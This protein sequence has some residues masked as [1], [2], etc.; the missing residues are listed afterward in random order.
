MD[1][2]S[3]AG[4]RDVAMTEEAKQPLFQLDREYAQ[5]MIAHAEEEAPNECCGLLAGQGGRIV[6]LYRA[7]NAERSPVRYNVDPKELLAIYNEI[8]AQGWDLLGI[9]HSH[10]HSEAYP[11]ATDVRLAAWPETLYFIVSLREPKRPA[12]RAY[13][14]VG[15]VISEEEL[16][17]V[18]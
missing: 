2:G 13:R 12:V 3:V 9:Y 8:D 16:A 7:R 18:G 1:S 5:L 11:S 10:T 15:G 6:K 17:I 14:I 4:M